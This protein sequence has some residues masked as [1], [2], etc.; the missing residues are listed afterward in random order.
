MSYD[1]ILVEHADGVCTITMN[2]PERLNAWTYQ[3]GDELSAAIEAGN[4]DDDVIAFVLTGAGRGFC[5]GADIQDVFKAQSDGSGPS[6]SEVRGE[7]TASNWVDLVRASKPMVAAVNGAAIGVG[8]TQILPMDS[9]VAAAGAKLSVRFIKMGV[10]PELASS[11]FLPARVG[12]GAANELML[13]GKT[14]S[15]EEALAIGLVDRVAAPEDLLDV[16]RELA[17]AMGENP[18]VA[19]RAVKQLISQNMGDSD[20]TAVQ[21]REI[22]ALQEAYKSPE[23]KEAIAAFMEKRAP[24]FRAARRST[25]A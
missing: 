19:L 16:A 14:V 22:I 23:H 2:R 13:T 6:R 11:H 7:N 15:A 20:L 9:I 24:D 18:Q 12:F 10:V 5:A 1:T 21:K 4:A 17:V 8:L 25:S 3:M